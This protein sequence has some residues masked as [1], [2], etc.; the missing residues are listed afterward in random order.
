[1]SGAGARR[2]YQT[3]AV[4]VREGRVINRFSKERIGILTEACELTDGKPGRVRIHVV[5]VPEVQAS[6]GGGGCRRWKQKI[7]RRMVYRTAVE[8]A[9]RTSTLRELVKRPY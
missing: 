4:P 6:A 3:C 2:E 9:P 8:S 1:M 7:H 5:D